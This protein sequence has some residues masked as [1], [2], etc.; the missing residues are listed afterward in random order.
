MRRGGLD[1]TPLASAGVVGVMTAA[2][3]L[4][5]LGRDVPSLI[6]APGR[7][8]YDQDGL[9]WSWGRSVSLLGLIPVV[10]SVPI[11]CGLLLTDIVVFVPGV[12]SLLWALFVQIAI[13]ALP[14]ELFFREATLKVFRANLP[15]AFGVSALAMVLYKLPEGLPAALIA[16]GGA[17]A[18]MALRVAGMNILLVAVVHGTTAVL[19]GRVLV[20]ELSGQALWLYATCCMLGHAM[21]ALAVVTVL[22]ARRP[23]VVEAGTEA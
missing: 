17:F 16:A 7:R 3:A 19:F 21:F 14:Q 6:R 23:I 1:L 5:L 20:A 10:L 8:L 22:R 11:A 15:G 13:I 4:F 9:G 2:F 18:F 12:Q